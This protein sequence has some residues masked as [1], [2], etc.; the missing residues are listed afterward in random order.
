MVTDTENELARVRDLLRAGRLVEAADACNARLQHHPDDAEALYF[1]GIA[2]HLGGDQIKAETLIER[3]LAIEPA[4]AQGW[5]NLAAIRLAGGKSEPARTAAQAAIERDPALAGPWLVIGNLEMR[6]GRTTAAR[7]A[8]AHAVEA[9]PSDADALS[10]LGAAMLEAGDA[11][12]A[13]I[14]L[15]K[16]MALDPGSAGA[17]ADLAGARQAMGDYDSA[18]TAAEC[19]LRINPALPEALINL[20]LAFRQQ[21]R[22]DD[23]AGAYRRAIALAP[24]S[25]EAHFN[26]SQ[27]LLLQR[28]SQDAWGEYEWRWRRGELAALVRDFPEPLWDGRPAP[29]KHLF[30]HMEQGFGDAFQFVRYCA[31]ARPL[32]GKLSV[33]CDARVADLMRT[34]PGV[35]AVI[36]DAAEVRNADFRLPMM[37]LPRLFETTAASIPADVPYLQATGGFLARHGLDAGAGLKIGLC[38]SGSTTFKNNRNR[39]TNFRTMRRLLD[40]AGCRFFS[41]QMDTPRQQLLD[42]DIGDEIVD[43][44]PVLKSFSDTASAMQDLDLVISTDTSVPHLAGAL[45]RPVWIM[46]HRAP[47]WRW[48]LFG[49][50]SPWYPTAKLYRQPAAGDWASVVDAVRNALAGKAGAE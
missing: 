49:D 34:A 16:A 28:L 24:D 40:V 15:E 2:A 7:Q 14:A 11:K 43:L 12:A 25:A 44:A 33:G 6:D 9:D 47:D 10:N 8:F 50:I 45:A 19:A 39:S 18:V 21:G 48:G 36:S 13:V 29:G 1:A 30:V 32:V 22:I 37:S 35:D 20:G 42:A 4:P 41:L 46:L 23:A 38:W 31:L 5:A 3:S 27:I 17:L 26:L